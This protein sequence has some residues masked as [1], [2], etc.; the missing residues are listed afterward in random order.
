VPGL[1]ERRLL[2]IVN[3]RAT[4]VD[5][6]ARKAAA[7]AL[8]SRFRVEL[9]TTASRGNATELAR[10]ALNGG[11]EGVV[12]FGG[13]G[14]FNEVADALAGTDLPVAILPGGS[15]N[16][17]ARTLGI[18]RDAGAAVRHLLSVTEVWNP[19]RIDLGIANERHFAFA[20]GV[21]LDAAVV[22]EIN[23][24]SRLP[25]AAL[26][27]RYAW[28]ALSEFAR[29]YLRDPATMR[30][31]A[32]DREVEAVTVLAQNIDPLTYLYSRPIRVCEGAGLDSGDFSLAALRRTHLA[33]TPALIARIL[34]GRL[35]VPRHRTVEHFSGLG[36]A[37]IEST[38]AQR[39]L[40]L[41][42]DGEFIGEHRRVELGI[43]PA[44][45]AVL[46]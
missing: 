7:E 33:H 41:Q 25:A 38:S 21:G 14:T 37:V 15:T 40:P 16:V 2:V 10:G 34:V 17:V 39:P 5:N 23:A 24:G 26:P 6:R 3:P 19:R 20:S 32:G 4:R 42:V 22:R 18:P 36:E 28:L 46:A 43:D 29:E 31:Q 44:A 35:R 9:A 27:Y 1:P 45:L 11:Y 13:D 30:V 8:S 12:A